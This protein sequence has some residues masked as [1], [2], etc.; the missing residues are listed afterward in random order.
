MKPQSLAAGLMLAGLQMVSADHHHG[1]LHFRHEQKPAVQ[2]YDTTTTTTTSVLKVVTITTTITVSPDTAPTIVLAP[3]AEPTSSSL[4]TASID[5]NTEAVASIANTQSSSTTSP[6]QGSKTNP[7]TPNGIKAGSA[8][9]D[10]Y[11]FWKDH[12][13]W[14]YDWTPN[15]LKSYP[16]NTG[17]AIPISMLWGAGTVSHGDAVRYAE[18]QKLTAAPPYILGYE[19]P[20]CSPPD[21][22]SISVQ[23][24]MK[25]WNEVVAPWGKKGSLLGSPS[26]CKQSDEDWLTPFQKGISTPWDFTAVHINTNNMGVVK[27]VLNHYWTKYN[28]KPIWVTEFACVDTSNGFK[29]SENQTQINKFIADIVDLFQRDDRVYAYAYSAGRGLGSTWP[30]VKDEKLTESGRVYLDAIRKYA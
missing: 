21:S 24:G 26:V 15:P 16:D 12:I 19:E 3:I 13:G 18:F 5:S 25:V 17:H 29:A 10:A 27:K 23:K 22:S 4:P 9:G 8:G 28:Q 14:W 2:E 6:S 11:P 1:A 7:L 30:P 20:D